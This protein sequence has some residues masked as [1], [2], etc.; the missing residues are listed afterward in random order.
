MQV[1]ET[2]RE[3][4]AFFKQKRK[5]MLSKEEKDLAI[6]NNIKADNIYNKIDDAFIYVSSEIEVDTKSLIS[7]M[8]SDGIKVA[9]PVSYP[10]DR[11][12]AFYY[13]NSLSE[14]RP[15]NYG[16]LEPDEKKA[17]KASFD[18]NTVCFVPALS[19]DKNGFRLGFGKGYYDRFLSSFNGIT[20]GLCYEECICEKLI[21]D[22]FDRR[23]QSVMTEKGFLNI[24]ALD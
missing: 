7:Q 1:S 21:H 24:I 6:L 2:K 13:I 11:S 4:R 20:V 3:L 14:L 8:L 15:G 19:F 22:N 9:V 18:E 12:M 17:K 5:N 16:I 23:V 10:K